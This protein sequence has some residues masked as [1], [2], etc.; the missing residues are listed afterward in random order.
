MYPTVVE[1][2]PVESVIVVVGTGPLAATESS[3]VEHRKYVVNE[4]C[5]D[6]KRPVRSALSTMTGPA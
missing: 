6:V 1:L 3:D 4:V 5:V 2:D